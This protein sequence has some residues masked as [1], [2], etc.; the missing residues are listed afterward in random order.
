[1]NLDKML[2]SGQMDKAFEWQKWCGEIPY[3][4]FPKDWEVQVIPPFCAAVVRF[5]AR[6]NKKEISVYLDCYDNLGFFGEP[7]WEAYPI[8]DNNN[9]YAMNDWKKLLKDMEAEFKRKN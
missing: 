6:K 3:I 9:R 1:M 5:R 7:H 8:K 2:L 4:K